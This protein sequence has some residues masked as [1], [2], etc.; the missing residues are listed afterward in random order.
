MKIELITDS[1]GQYW[2]AQ[3]RVRG[4]LIIAEGD[5]RSDAMHGFILLS[6]KV[7]L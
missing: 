7:F 6:N 5:T 4:R 1:S 2:V 3:G